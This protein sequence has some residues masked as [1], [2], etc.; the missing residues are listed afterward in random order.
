MTSPRIDFTHL[1]NMTS[2]YGT[3]E[4][5]RFDVARIEHGHCTD[6]VARVLIVAARQGD[7]DPEMRQL[8]TGSLRFLLRTQD[9]NGL[10]RNRRSHSGEWTDHAT[11]EDAWGR[12]MWAFGT[13]VAL[14]TSEELRHDALLAFERSALVTTPWIRATAFS[15][16]GALEILGV[17]PANAA[18]REVLTRART[19]LD[20][21]DIS[22]LWRW[23]E[24]Q[25]RYANAALCDALIGIGVFFDD[26]GLQTS[27]LRQL[28]WLL[29]QESLPGFLSVTPVGGRTMNTLARTFD[30]QPIEVAAMAD[31]CVRAWRCTHDEFWATGLRQCVGWF[32]GENELGVAMFNEHD[33]G[34]YD[35][36]SAHGANLNEGAESTIAFLTTMQ[37]ARVFAVSS[38]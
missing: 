17:D 35:G 14:S 4:H 16:L 20:R 2:P 33:G 1:I 38:T 13:A 27:A 19:T 29:E 8:S 12:A 31:A 6:D 30:Q 37:Q 26:E 21:P 3:F 23:P 10:V 18:A 32:L 24:E 7:D 15:A 34:G 5:A 22:E 11:N 25:L 9:S 36:L 28:R